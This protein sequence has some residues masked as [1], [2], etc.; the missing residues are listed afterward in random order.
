ML[1]I[2]ISKTPLDDESL[3][4]QERGR[5]VLEGGPQYQKGGL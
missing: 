3:V 5:A 1:T 4:P 2:P